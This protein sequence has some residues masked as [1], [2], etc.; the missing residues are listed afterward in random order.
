MITHDIEEALLLADEVLVLSRTPMQIM[1]RF[2]LSEAKP[3]HISDPRLIEIKEHVLNRLQKE[4][5]S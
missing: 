3:R 1:E 5:E 4:L 2:V